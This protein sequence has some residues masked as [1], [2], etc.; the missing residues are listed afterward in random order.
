[1]GIALGKTAEYMDDLYR[2]LSER[3]HSEGIS[4]NTAIVNEALDMLLEDS[5]AYLRVKDRLSVGVT[6]FPLHHRRYSSWESNDDLRR[7]LHGSM[8]L[9]LYCDMIEP[10]DGKTV[11]DGG[12]SFG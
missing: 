1:L 2:T 10:V 9:P 8:Y 12:F 4:A 3:A 6:E 7:C 5:Q 11:V